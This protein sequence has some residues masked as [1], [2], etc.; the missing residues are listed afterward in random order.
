MNTSESPLPIVDLERFMG[1]WY[2]VAC[3]PTLF[4]RGIRD[5]VHTYRLEADG[6]IAAMVRYRR[7]RPLGP[8]RSFGMR[9]FVEDH[10][11]NAVWTI[12][13]VWPFRT[14][15]RIMAVDPGYSYAVIGRNRRGFAW[16]LSRT[17]EMAHR[18]FF[19][20]VRVLRERGY[21]ADRLQK[22]PHSPDPRRAPGNQTAPRRAS[23]CMRTS[24]AFSSVIE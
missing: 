12:R 16:I 18:D 17:P 1:R 9:G 19:A 4:E 6:T 3:L 2:V 23:S 15:Y 14:D 20:S 7:K 22:V 5:A 13:P 21:D 11:R 8:L 10:E 24:C